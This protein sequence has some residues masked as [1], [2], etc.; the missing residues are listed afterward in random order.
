MNKN[1]DL[2]KNDRWVK[3]ETSHEI[4]ERPDKFAE[5][6]D[7]L[8]GSQNKVKEVFRR[9]IVSLLKSNIEARTELKALIKEVEKE[10]FR[11][12]IKKFG[13]SIW[14]AI[15]FVCGSVATIIISKLLEK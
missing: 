15:V 8:C 5:Y 7:D 6:F 9:E 12:L 4:L 11:L 14:S 10:D 3:L 13:F 2:F 1:E